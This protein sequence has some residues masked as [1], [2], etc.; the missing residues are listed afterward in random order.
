[1][2]LDKFCVSAINFVLVVLKNIAFQYFHLI[3]HQKLGRERLSPINLYNLFTCGQRENGIAD[4]NVRCTRCSSHVVYADVGELVRR[5]GVE[6]CRLQQ[7]CKTCRRNKSRRWDEWWMN[8]QKEWMNIRNITPY[9][10]LTRAKKSTGWMAGS[11]PPSGMGCSTR[12]RLLAEFFF[13]I[14]HA[15]SD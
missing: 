5:E 1:M 7:R 15:K 2:T 3:N 9:D 12:N 14:K 10:L 8:G 13:C 4:P 11:H 6:E